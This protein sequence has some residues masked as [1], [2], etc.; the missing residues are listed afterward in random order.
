MKWSRPFF[1]SCIRKN[2][3]PPKPELIGSTTESVAET[4]TA[5]SKALPPLA[6]ISNP[7]SVAK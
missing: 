3:P 6:N 4:A 2:P 7:A 5:A 1:A